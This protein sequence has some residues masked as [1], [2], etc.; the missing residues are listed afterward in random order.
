MKAINGALTEDYLTGSSITVADFCVAAGHVMAFQTLLD[1]GF[2][3]A[4]GKAS[5]WFKRVIE[6]PAFI[7]VAGKVQCCAKA[8]KPLVKVEEKKKP[9]PKAA[10]VKKEEKKVE[11]KGL[12][13]LPPTDFE[14]YDY[15]TFY[16]NHPDKKGEAIEK[17]KEMFRSDKFADGFSYWHIKYEKYG[18]EGQVQYKF[19][20][21]LAGFMQRTDTKLSRFAFGRML[22]LGEEPKL[23]IEGCW[24]FRG[25]EIPAEMLDHPQ[26][27]YFEK[28]KLDFLGNAADSK[29]VGEF[30]GCP[31]KDGTCLGRAVAEQEWFK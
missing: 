12:D 29:L 10:P 11:K 28:R 30:F 5:A 13:A 6:H 3:K 4:M 20:N 31:K 17:T 26:L 14:L 23:D 18:D 8:L 19:S 27:E 2:C 15:K 9:E 16:V 25:Q 21:L 22:M 24:M 7:K 1:A